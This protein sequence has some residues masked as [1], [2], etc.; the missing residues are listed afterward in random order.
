[1]INN[2]TIRNRYDKGIDIPTGSSTSVKL[3][4]SLFE[5][6]PVPYSDCQ[7]LANFDS[8]LYRAILDQN[9]TYRQEDCFDLCLQKSNIEKCGCCNLYFPCLFNKEF[10]LN[11]T[12]VACVYQTYKN[13]INSNVND[14]CSS[15]CPIECESME[16]DVTTSSSAFPTRSFYEFYKDNKYFKDKF[17]NE[18]ITYDML[19]ENILELN[20]YYDTFKYINTEQSPV[21]TIID[22]ISNIGGTLGLLIGISL[23][24]LVEILEIIIE[25][26]LTVFEY[27]NSSKKVNMSD[28]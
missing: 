14:L 6:L 12:Q 16:I 7:D 11:P 19:K 4:R 18:T 24:S 13:F 2:Q 15:M 10:C 1:M 5:K 21:S 22:L 20:I 26:I 17:Q 25:I 3:K 8:V 27:S 9:L 28:A 23:L